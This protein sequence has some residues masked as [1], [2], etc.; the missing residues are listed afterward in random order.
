MYSYGIK[1]TAALSNGLSP[2]WRNDCAALRLTCKAFTDCTS[3]A[4]FETYY[5][6]PMFYSFA[7]LEALTVSPLARHV[8]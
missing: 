3:N 8:R 6:Y 5:L 7:N 4:L 1:E 2:K